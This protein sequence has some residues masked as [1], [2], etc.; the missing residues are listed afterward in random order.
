MTSFRSF[1]CTAAFASIATTSIA[2]TSLTLLTE[3]Y[4]P[5]NYTENG[6]IVGA[7]TELVQE[8]MANLRKGRTSFVIAH[9]LSTVK[10]ADRVMVL[11]GGILC[12]VGT[13]DE[14][15]QHKEGIYRKL[16]ERQFMESAKETIEAH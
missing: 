8:A 2:D 11:D 10:D 12:E 7:A 13:H 3:E 14:L 9:R 15:M 4:P 6:E 5:Y 16:V 1:I